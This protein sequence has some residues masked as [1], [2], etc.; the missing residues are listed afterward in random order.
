ME[1]MDGTGLIF[2]LI[3]LGIIVIFLVALLNQLLN[4]S[5][6]DVFVSHRSLDNKTIE[7]IIKRLKDKRFK[8]WIDWDKIDARPE[9]RPLFKG[10]IAEG[11]QLSSHALLFTATNYR[12]SPYC[13]EE[14]DFFLATRH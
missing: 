3:L 5:K 11:I 2:I 9:F 13:L 12:A 1:T 4:R 8:I 14:A 6:W 7:P 10:I